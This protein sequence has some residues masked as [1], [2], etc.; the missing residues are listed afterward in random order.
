MFK[1]YLVFV[2]VSNKITCIAN[3]NCIVILLF[4]VFKNTLA[5]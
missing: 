5:V 2:I 3:N 4:G 1:K